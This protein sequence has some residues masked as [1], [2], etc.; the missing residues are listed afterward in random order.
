MYNIYENMSLN[1]CIL[2]IEYGRN[3]VYNIITI[4][5]KRKRERKM[6]NL[7]LKNMKETLINYSGC[8]SEFDKIWDAF[9]EMSCVGF[10]DQNTWRKFYD[11]CKGWYVSEDEAEIRDSEREDKLV[12]KYTSESEYK[13]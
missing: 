1:S 2:S 3:I 9:Y 8:Q 11:Q 10:I 12:W 13:A 7:N 5:H 4:K 6:K